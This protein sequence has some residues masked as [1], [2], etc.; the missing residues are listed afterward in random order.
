MQFWLAFTL[1][2]AHG[3]LQ[4]LVMCWVA[5]IYNCKSLK[6]RIDLYIKTCISDLPGSS[7]Y[8]ILLYF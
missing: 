3:Q 8:R 2:V 7:E 4:I 5:H 1:A 6:L